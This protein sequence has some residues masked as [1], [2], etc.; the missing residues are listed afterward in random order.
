M[1]IKILIIGLGKIGF[2][3]D[4]KKKVYNY[5]ALKNNSFNLPF[6]KINKI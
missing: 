4:F 5:L 3:Y 2:D 6:K 1:K